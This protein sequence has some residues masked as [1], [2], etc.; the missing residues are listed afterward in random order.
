MS[1]DDKGIVGTIIYWILVFLFIKLLFHT[2]KA[3]YRW[4]ENK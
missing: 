4:I 3:I 2:I 1:K